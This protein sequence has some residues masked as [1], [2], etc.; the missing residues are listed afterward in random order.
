MTQFARTMFLLA[1][2]ISYSVGQGNVSVIVDSL[3][4]S[5]QLAL[6]KQLEEARIKLEQDRIKAVQYM[7][8]KALSL[9]QQRLSA[10][11]QIAVVPPH[12]EKELQAALP[13]LVARYPD[14]AAYAPE[15]I[16]LGTIFVPGNSPQT[17]GEV[18]L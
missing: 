5:Q 1:I 12:L 9:E 10:A 6:Q 8:D 3:G 14:L 17:T 16:R 11:Q 15:M 18:Y 13:V 4:K 2:S 7:Y